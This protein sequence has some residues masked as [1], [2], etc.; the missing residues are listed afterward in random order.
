MALRW[1]AEAKKRGPSVPRELLASDARVSELK[2]Q[3]RR[4]SELCQWEG[5]S[6]S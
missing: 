6:V 4:P 2:R 5:R 3:L 1:F